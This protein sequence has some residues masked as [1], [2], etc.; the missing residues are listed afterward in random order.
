[1]PF[2]AMT[3]ALYAVPAAARMLTLSSLTVPFK[4]VGTCAA[5]PVFNTPSPPANC[6]A[7]WSV[8]PFWKQLL[9]TRFRRPAASP[10]SIWRPSNH[11]VPLKLRVLAR[12]L[13]EDV[14]LP[15]PLSGAVKAT[16]RRLKPSVPAVM[17]TESATTARFF[18]VSSICSQIRPFAASSLTLAL[19]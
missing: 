2:G 19:T 16:D 13:K 14:P 4:T 6:K 17:P 12:I 3:R 5:A 18:A 10:S 11:A 9:E 7:V 1:M 8:M 15:V